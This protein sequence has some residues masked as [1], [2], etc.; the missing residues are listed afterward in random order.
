MEHPTLQKYFAINELSGWLEIKLQGDNVLDRD[1]GED[2][3]S[4]Y[5]NLEDNYLGN[6]G[7]SV[8][9]QKT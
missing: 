5:I 3:Y 8:F 2:K 9:M 6:G 1:H 4:I 7:E